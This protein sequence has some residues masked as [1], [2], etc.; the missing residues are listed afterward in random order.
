[1]LSMPETIQLDPSQVPER[2]RKWIPLAQRWGGQ[3]DDDIV[4]DIVDDATRE[5]LDELLTLS[6]A[7]NADWKALYAWLAGPESKRRPPTHEYCAFTCLTIALD[8]A[9]SRRKR[10][11]H[12]DAF[13]TPK[14][15]PIWSINAILDAQYA[16]RPQLRPICDAIIDAA[17]AFR[18][19]GSRGKPDEALHEVGV[20]PSKHWIELATQRR[21]FA[22]I[23]PTTDGRVI[24]YLCL[25]ARPPVGRLK[26]SQPDDALPLQISIASLDEW[27]GEAETWLHQA[28]KENR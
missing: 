24:L 6:D 28:Y 20:I 11:E 14:P 1:V 23:E 17:S 3:L 9:R 16:G 12:P 4:G 8:Y 27:D 21:S 5:E 18:S 10:E 25:Q 19:L 26:P 2:F 7:D 15:I 13:R 22:R